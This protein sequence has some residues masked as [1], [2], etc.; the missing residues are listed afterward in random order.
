MSYE[1]RKEEFRLYGPT[2]TILRILYKLSQSDVASLLDV[3]KPQ[4]SQAEV[5]KRKLTR[6]QTLLLLDELGITEANAKKFE[7]SIKIIGNYVDL[8]RL[9]R[10]LGLNGGQ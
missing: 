4:I 7:S 6:M 8:E 2:L 5:G 9:E 1:K 10:E 3:K